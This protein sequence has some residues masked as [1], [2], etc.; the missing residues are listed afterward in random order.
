MPVYNGAAHIVE[1]VQ[2]VLAQVYTDFELIVVDD[3]STDGTAELLR[4]YRGQLRLIRQE[5]QG[6][7]AARNHGLRLALGEFILFLDGDDLLYPDKL[8]HQVALLEAD[9]LLGAVHS[10]WRLVDEYGRSLRRIRPWLQTPDLTLTDWLRWKPVFLGAMLFRRGWL[11]RINGFRTDLRQA[12]DTDFL[13]RLSLA[14]CPMRWY[15]RLTIDYRQHGAGVTQ[16]GRRQAKDLSTV[17]DDFFGNEALPSEIKALAPTVQQYTALWLVWQLHRTGY[18]EE[19]AP[20]LQRAMRANGEH[21]PAVLA[22][23]WL[24][25][26]AAYG[27]E[28]GEPVTHMRA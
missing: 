18:S 26:L 5:N 19:I 16:N 3:G 14:G 24:V 6:V 11:Q 4:P 21:P 7:S 23:T 8:K 27:R 22:Q 9:H 10:G 2:S 1:T 25:Q 13:L 17:L 15:K 12:E 20:Y 28:E